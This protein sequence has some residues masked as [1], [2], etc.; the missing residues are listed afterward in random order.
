MESDFS[1]LIFQHYFVKLFR[2]H[3]YLSW[4]ITI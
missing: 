2:W 4:I 1:S 3:L